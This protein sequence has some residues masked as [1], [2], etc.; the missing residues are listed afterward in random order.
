MEKNEKLSNHESSYDKINNFL[1]FTFSLHSFNIYPTLIPIITYSVLGAYPFSI[2]IIKMP[3]NINSASHIF[4]G[5]CTTKVSSC[6]LITDS[7]S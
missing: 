4:Y 7:R 3:G 1:S 6:N 2:F 5:K